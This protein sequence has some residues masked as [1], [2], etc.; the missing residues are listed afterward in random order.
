MT[1]EEKQMRAM[2]A[3]RIKE[4]RL[5]KNMTQYDLVKALAET[6][7]KDIKQPTISQYEAGNIKV[8][9]FTLM[10]ICMALGCSLD[11]LIGRDVLGDKN[12]RSGR[13]LNSF[14]SMNEDEQE[15]V[16]KMIEFMC[17]K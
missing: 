8:D 10:A 3:R 9:L 1:N 7:N 11:Y 6:D 2:I 16:I 14:S 4:I 12:S 13:L 17:K 5:T 15:I